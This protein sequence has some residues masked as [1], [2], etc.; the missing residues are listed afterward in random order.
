[1]STR[2]FTLVEMLVV[3][4]IVT[5]LATVAVPV[6][7]DQLIRSRRADA[8]ALLMDVAARQ[9]SYYRDNRTFTTDMTKLGFGSDP[10]IAPGGHYSIDTAAGATASIATSF[11]ATATRLDTQLADTRCGDF[12][13]N[14]ERVTGVVN[15][16]TSNPERECW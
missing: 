1:M 15:H 12:T 4:A 16:S 9:E 14:S 13:I 2:G 5:V 10:V 7:R 8:Q 3:V 11:I 6:Y